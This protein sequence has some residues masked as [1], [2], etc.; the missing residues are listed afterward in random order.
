MCPAPFAYGKHI[1]E[2]VS[3]S[4]RRG[5]IL[6]LAGLVGA[7]RSELVSAIYGLTDKISGTLYFDGKEVTHSTPEN[8]IRMGMVS[9]RKTEKRMALSGPWILNRI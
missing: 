3:F 2:D 4:I 5:E 8:S 7:G 9:C 6:G 1:I